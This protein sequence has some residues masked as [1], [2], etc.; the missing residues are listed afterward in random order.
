MK[1]KQPELTKMSTLR[2]A[3][4]CALTVLIFLAAI[5]PHASAAFEEDVDYMSVMI[6]ACAT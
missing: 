6:S 3:F 5:T 2:V 4:L 1:F